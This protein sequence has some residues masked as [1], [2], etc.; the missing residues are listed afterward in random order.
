MKIGVV[1]KNKERLVTQGSNQ[2]EGID[3]EETFEPIARLEAIKIFLAYATYMSFMVYQMDVKSAFLN[4][5]ILEEVYVQ[6]PL[7]FESSGLP[8]HFC[9]LEQALYGLKQALR[10]W[11]QANPNESY[12][13]AVK[14]IFRYLKVTQNLG[15][16][17]PKGPGF[18]LKAY[19][20]SDYAGFN[21][22]KRVPQ[23]VVKY[24]VENVVHKFSRS[25]VS[26]L[27]MM[28]SMTRYH[29]IR[30]HILNGD[31]ELHFIPTDL[32][33]ADTFTKLLP[34]P[35]FT[36]L[37]AELER[38]KDLVSIPPKETVKAGLATLGLTDENNTSLSSSDLINSSPMK[39]KYFSPK[40]RVLMQYI[41]HPVTGK[42][43]I[44]SNICHTRYLS[45]ILEHLMA[46]SKPHQVFTPYLWEVNAD[47]LADKSSS[48]TSVQPVI[49]SKAPTDS[50]LKKKRIPPSSK[51]KSS[52]Q[53]RDVPQKKQVAETQ[54]AE[55]KMAITNTTQSLGASESAEDQ[56]NHPKTADVEKDTGINYELISIGD[57]RLEDL[58][59]HVEESPYDTESEIKVI[60]RFQPTQMDD[61]D[62]IIFLGPE[63]DD[64]NQRMEEPTDSDL[65][66][67]PDDEVVS[68]YGFRTNDS[69]EE[70]TE[71]TEPKVTLTQSEEANAGNLNNEITNLNTSAAKTSDP[72]WSSS[73]EYSDDRYGG[74]TTQGRCNDKCS[75]EHTSVQE[76]PSSEQAPLVTENANQDSSISEPAQT[77]SSALVVHTP[78]E[79]ASED[80]FIDSLFR[81]TSSEYSPTPPRDE[82]KGNGI[83]VEEEP[84]KLLMP[85][86]DEQGGSD[87]KMLKLH[88][89]SISGMKMTL[90]DA[91]AQLIEM[92]RL[93]DLKAE[94]EKLKKKLKKLSPAEIEA[95]AQKLAEFEAK[96]K[97]MLNE[98][99][100]YITYRADKLL[101]IKIGYKID[102][103]TKDATMRIERN[104]QPL[105]LTVYEKFM[106]KQLGF[107][108]WIEIHALASK[109]KSKSNDLLKNLKA[110]F[111]WIKTQAEKL[112]IP[113]PSELTAF[114]LSAAKKLK[115][116]P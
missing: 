84:I 105:S 30:D 46:F 10:A 37:V 100:H 72:L 116:H 23:G 80:K 49:Q 111:E 75:G 13:V 16:W 93:A 78:E 12:L 29:F 18:D 110:K 65:H 115:N 33:L 3:Y 68:I 113:P 32:Q 94:Q 83:A 15:L 85:L 97:K 22:D 55:K 69:N 35:S 1:I 4:G 25:R 9:K 14:R 21:L 6:Q 106:L 88:Q 50:K 95:Q 99:N 87:P 31:I 11:Y 74:A 62:Q 53:V 7:R 89:F 101:I 103:V 40:W 44:K 112:G 19:Y 27:T 96:R 61:E 60:K 109:V 114:G 107:S 102:R 38:S 64:L 47:D 67:I 24:L 90:E 98:Y 52:K 79:K 45:L 41:V 48:E 28:F 104:K 108:E 81:T 8:N 66:S 39:I 20:D 59:G 36:R 5:K 71:Y 76:I 77:T 58:S 63:P 92:K 91:Q 17:Y 2:Q 51:P 86:E 26:W 73:H 82:S 42:K 70:G 54:H 57:V 43:E 56:V 34:E